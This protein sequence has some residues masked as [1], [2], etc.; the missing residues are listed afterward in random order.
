MSCGPVKPDFPHYSWVV[1][2]ESE[3]VEARAGTS[4]TQLRDVPARF[5]IIHAFQHSTVRVQILSH[6]FET[7]YFNDFD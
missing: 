1:W 4:D 7:I 3:E 5:T 2:W 6:P